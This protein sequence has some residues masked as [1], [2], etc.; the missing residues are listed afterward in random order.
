MM[1]NF[2]ILGKVYF[3]ISQKKN[4]QLAHEGY[5]YNKKLNQANGHTTW[6]CSDVLKTKCKAVIITKN[7]KIIA[8]RRNHTHPQHWARIGNRTLFAEEDNLG[9]FLDV[10]T[11]I[12]P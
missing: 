4:A 6:R 5:I 1:I 3:V 9:E 8:V 11:T 7:N 10:N 12:T 2:L